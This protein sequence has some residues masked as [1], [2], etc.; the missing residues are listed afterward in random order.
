MRYLHTVEKDWDND[1]Q[2]IMCYGMMNTAEPSLPG[3]LMPAKKDIVSLEQLQLSG[4]YR[5]EIASGRDR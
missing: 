4:K 5:A 3:C 2:S 1:A